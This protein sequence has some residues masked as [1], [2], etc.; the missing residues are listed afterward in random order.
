LQI[1]R[2]GD[3]RFGLRIRA[4]QKKHSWS[5][6]DGGEYFRISLRRELQALSQHRMILV[7]I[8]GGGSKQTDAFLIR[9]KDALI[10]REEV[11]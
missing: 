10:R 8:Y 4:P 7:G 6:R 5:R 3:V 11:T 9:V 1:R 2:F